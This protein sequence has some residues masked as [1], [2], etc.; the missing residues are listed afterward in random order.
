MAKTALKPCCE[1]TLNT[2][3]KNIRN[4]YTSFP[5][6]KDVPCPTCRQIIQVRVYEK[7][8]AEADS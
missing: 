5:V 4:N 6:I 7:S 2:Y 1:R 3:I 8:T